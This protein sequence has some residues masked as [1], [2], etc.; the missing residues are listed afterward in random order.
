[1]GDLLGGGVVGV[2]E[3]SA[4]EWFAVD[5]ELFDELP[6]VWMLVVVLAVVGAVWVLL[7]FD[8]E[9]EVPVAVIVCWGVSVCILVDVCMSELGMGMQIFPFC[10]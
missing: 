4:L 5:L 3:E 9:P 6:V 1:V 7:E 2:L 8:W 10:V